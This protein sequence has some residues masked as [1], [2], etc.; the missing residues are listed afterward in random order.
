MKK[1]ENRNK[2]AIKTI[3]KR[4]QIKAENK[5]KERQMT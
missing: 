2:N 3:L 1:G 4:Q 5:I